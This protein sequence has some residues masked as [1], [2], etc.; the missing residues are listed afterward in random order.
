MAKL[1]KLFHSS[2]CF[3]PTIV[4]Y[5]LLFS[6]KQCLKKASFKFSS[7]LDQ[8]KWIMEAYAIYSNGQVKPQFYAF[9]WITLLLSQEFN[10]QSI[11]RIWDSLLSNPFGVQVPLKYLDPI[12][13]WWFKQWCLWKQ[14]WFCA[15]YAFA[16]LL[17]N[18]VMH[19]KQAIEWWFCS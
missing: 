3:V 2:E 9:R 4:V 1:K 12:N 19:E 17:C 15:G 11:L 6:S 5:L 16:D 13:F 18:A 10:F 8:A 14:N 7:Y